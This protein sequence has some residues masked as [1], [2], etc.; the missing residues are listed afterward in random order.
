MVVGLTSFA[1]FVHGGILVAPAEA[2]GQEE[3]ADG[4]LSALANRAVQAFSHGYPVGRWSRCL[5]AEYAIR[6]GTAM[7]LRRRVAVVAR[8]CSPPKIVP[9]ARSP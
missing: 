7:T 2:G 5:L 4:G 6:A 1:S 3:T 8:A 9:V